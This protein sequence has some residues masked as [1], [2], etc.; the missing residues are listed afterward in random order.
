V[1]LAQSSRCDAVSACRAFLRSASRTGP[2][3]QLVG[4]LADIL[5]PFLQSLGERY[6]L[7]ESASSL[8]DTTSPC[9]FA[10]LIRRSPSVG[11]IPDISNQA[12][13]FFKTGHQGLKQASRARDNV[14]ISTGA[15]SPYRDRC[16][17]GTKRTK[18]RPPSGPNKL[19][20]CNST[21]LKR[22]GLPEFRDQYAARKGRADLV[23][24]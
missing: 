11:S 21:L 7:L 19:G 23:S 6:G 5:S 9:T 8:H 24:D 16:A 15:R 3:G 22:E 4:F 20:P 12:T 10:I 13:A 17:Q 1:E 2:R 14:D 18:V